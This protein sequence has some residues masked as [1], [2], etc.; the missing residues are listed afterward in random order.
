MASLN[1]LA[2]TLNKRHDGETRMRDG[3]VENQPGIF[4]CINGYSQQWAYFVAHAA[5]HC[6]I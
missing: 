4:A 5:R 1:K 3:R 6:F 2:P